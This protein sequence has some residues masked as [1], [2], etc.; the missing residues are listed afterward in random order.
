VSEGVT[1]L[2]VQNTIF[3]FFLKGMQN[4]SGEF[5]YQNIKYRILVEWR[6]VQCQSPHTAPAISD[7]EVLPFQE[8]SHRGSHSGRHE[9]PVSV[10]L[11]IEHIP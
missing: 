8:L 7:D 4:G 6:R 3:L 2:Q 5:F 11:V 9:T 10:L 1:L